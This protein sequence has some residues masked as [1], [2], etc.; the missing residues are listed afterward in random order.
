MSTLDSLL[1]GI[2]ISWPPAIGGLWLT[3]FMAR[4]KVAEVTRKANER[5]TAV[6]TKL[7]NDQTATLL[8]AQAQPDAPAV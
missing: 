7:T 1:I 4:R 6:L 2:V 3:W 5:Q 8:D